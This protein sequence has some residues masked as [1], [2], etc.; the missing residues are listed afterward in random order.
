MFQKRKKICDKCDA[1]MIGDEYHVVL[2]SNN[3]VITQFRRSYIPEYFWISPNRHKYCVLMQSGNV[4]IL[5]KL[6]YFLDEVFNIFQ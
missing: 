4:T 6:V 3:Q 1:A 2:E 5:N